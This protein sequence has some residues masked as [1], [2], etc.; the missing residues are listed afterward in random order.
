MKKILLLL[1]FLAAAVFIAIKFILPKEEN[2]PDQPEDPYAISTND[3]GFQLDF[4]KALAGYFKM[5]DAF[6]E[7]DTL[8]INAAALRYDSSLSNLDFGPVEAAEP[9]KMQADMLAGTISRE[10]KALQLEPLLEDKRRSFQMVTD[11]FFDLMRTIR[12]TGITVYKQYCPMAF[13]NTGAYW[14]SN[15]NEVVNPYFGE[16]MLHCGEVVDSLELK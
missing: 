3:T 16:S 12:F 14:L 11:A 6:I 5:K 8:R 1:L 4:S 13:N 10:L 15:S 7:S 9:I 2:D